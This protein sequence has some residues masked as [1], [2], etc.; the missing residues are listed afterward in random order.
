LP[1]GA[2]PWLPFPSVRPRPFSSTFFLEQGARAE[3]ASARRRAP[4]SDAPGELC[5]RICVTLLIIVGTINHND[6]KEQGPRPIRPYLMA[7]STSTPIP[8]QHLLLHAP[9]AAPLESATH[10]MELRGSPVGT[11]SPI[12]ET[13]LPLLASDTRPPPT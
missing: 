1:T 4:I 6:R 9:R 12:T 7:R 3:L 11:K 8:R 2:G 13:G 10:E 5:K